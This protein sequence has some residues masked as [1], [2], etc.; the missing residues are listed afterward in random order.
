MQRFQVDRQVSLVN[1]VA[2]GSRTAAEAEA[3]MAAFKV[4]FIQA[5]AIT[6]AVWCSEEVQLASCKVPPG[7]LVRGSLRRYPSVQVDVPACPPTEAVL[8][9]IPAVQ[10]SHPGAQVSTYRCGQPA[11]R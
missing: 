8:R 1:E 10:G 4:R 3:E 9:V 11:V 7:H 5:S 6:H 2:R